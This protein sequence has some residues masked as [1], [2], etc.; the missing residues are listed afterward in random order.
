MKKLNQNWITEGTI[1]FEYKK[2][3]LLAYLQRINKDFDQYKL[4]PCLSD[5]IE[6]YRNLVELRTNQEA[7]YNQATGEITK[8]DLN[9]FIIEYERIIENDEYM[10]EVEQILDFAIP[11]I[12][13]FLKDGKEIY[14]FVEDKLRI[15][16]I[17]IMAIYTD[18]GYMLLSEN[19]KKDTMV[20]E[21]HMTF[22]ESVKERFRAIKTKYIT[23]YKHSI[24]NSY[25]NIK[26]DLVRTYKEF[27]NPATYMIESSRS[28]PLKETF[29]PIAKR[30]LVRYITTHSA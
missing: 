16:P 19:A 18:E 5:L 3:L 13:E 6:H 7:I 17:G 21:Y 24:A 9:N 8:I 11:K 29:L 28:F 26:I 22:F 2:Y 27:A 1:D 14:D 20:Y 25:E 12:V 30:S 10:E 23:T 4:Y 15:E